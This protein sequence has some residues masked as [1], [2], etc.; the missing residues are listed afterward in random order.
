MSLYTKDVTLEFPAAESSSSQE[1]QARLV[2]R[3]ITPGEVEDAARQIFRYMVAV[4]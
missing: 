1:D 3:S 2:S 4:W